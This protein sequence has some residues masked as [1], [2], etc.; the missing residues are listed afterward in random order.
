MGLPW[1]PAVPLAAAPSSA[2]AAPG[3]Y[4]ILAAGTLA[5]LYIGEAGS[6][7]ARLRAHA[8]RAWAPHDPLVSWNADP[9]LARPHHRHERESDL[10]GAYFGEHGRPPAFQYRSRSE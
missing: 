1:S 7:A 9:T 6:L 3:V 10:L 4:K 8:R 5:L 2:P